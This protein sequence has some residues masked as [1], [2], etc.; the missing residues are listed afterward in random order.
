MRISKYLN[1]YLHFIHVDP[2]S[3]P[4]FDSNEKM[5]WFFGWR[6]GGGGLWRRFSGE[7]LGIYNNAQLILALS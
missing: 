2:V 4:K 3:V 6:R 5:K 1:F 7:A